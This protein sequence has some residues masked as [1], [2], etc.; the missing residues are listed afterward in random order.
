MLSSVSRKMILSI[1][2]CK[3]QYAMYNTYEARDNLFEI[4]VYKI[5]VL[6]GVLLTNLSS[7]EDRLAKPGNV[8]E[9]RNGFLCPLN[10]L[11]A[12]ILL[13]LRQTFRQTCALTVDFFNLLNKQCPHTH[14][15]SSSADRKPF[16]LRLPIGSRWAFLFTSFKRPAYSGCSWMSLTSLS[17]QSSNWIWIKDEVS[18]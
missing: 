2:I 17:W 8:F 14:K 1:I 7:Y 6:H 10:W 3:T 18:R 9:R 13:F 11:S 15:N 5:K 16:A 12:N 4:A